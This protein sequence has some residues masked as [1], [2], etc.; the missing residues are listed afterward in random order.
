MLSCLLIALQIQV[1]I[2]NPEGD[3]TFHSSASRLDFKGYQAVYEVSS[4]FK[5]SRLLDPRCAQLC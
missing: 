1:D 2:G 5:L 3:V 4:K